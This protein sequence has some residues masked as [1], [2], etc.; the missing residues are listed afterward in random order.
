MFISARRT[1]RLAAT[2]ALAVA[3]ALGIPAG[4]VLLAYAPGGPTDIVA[5]FFAQER[6]S[7]GA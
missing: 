2:T 6:A 4:Q 7:I 3:L 5:R 1:A